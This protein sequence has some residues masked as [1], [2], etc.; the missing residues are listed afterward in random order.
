MEEE[1]EEKTQQFGPTKCSIGQYCPLIDMF[2][3]SI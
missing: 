3:F 2:F 1:I